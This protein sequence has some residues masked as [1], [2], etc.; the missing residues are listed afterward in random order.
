MKFHIVRN[1]ETIK[2]I[3]NTYSLT[4]NE[5]KEYNRHIKEW[6][7]LIPGTKL[8]IPI[9]NESVEQ[10]MIDMEPFIEEYYPRNDEPIF[11]NSEGF[12]ENQ[13][14]K[15]I[16]KIDDLEE[17]K[18]KISEN[19]TNEGIKEINEKKDEQKIK[20]NEYKNKNEQRSNISYIWYQPY[21][22]YYPIYI[23][24]K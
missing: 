17:V 9:I 16:D 5:L 14:D 8:K 4:I 23:R 12:E 20:E 7:K 21:P 3:L 11:Q 13:Y 1:H 19:K 2:E 18:E 15:D 24:V 22:V 10:D 6:N